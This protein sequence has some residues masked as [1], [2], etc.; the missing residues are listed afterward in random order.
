MPGKHGTLGKAARARDARGISR[1]RA[2]S[3]VHGFRPGRR[4][5]VSQAGGRSDR[6]ELTDADEVEEHDWRLGE[7][8]EKDVDGGRWKRMRRKEG[9]VDEE[10]E[11]CMNDVRRGRIR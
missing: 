8:G 11:G 1:F 2:H 5:I 6:D 4:R 9:E 3:A 10:E 7:E